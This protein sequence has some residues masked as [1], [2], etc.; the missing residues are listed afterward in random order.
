L[1]ADKSGQKL[2]RPWQVPLDGFPAPAVLDL[3]HLHWVAE[4]LVDRREMSVAANQ[5]ESRTDGHR[6]HEKVVAGNFQP[7]GAQRTF[8]AYP[9]A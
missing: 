7:F 3:I 5:R 8:Y 9:V 1:E 2:R 6:G 4:S